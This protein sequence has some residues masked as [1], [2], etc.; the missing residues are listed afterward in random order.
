[1]PS[2]IPLHELLLAE[3]YTYVLA[4]LLQN[5]AK[6]I[7]KLTQFQKSYYEFGSIQ[8]SSGK[9]KKLKFIGLHLS[10]NYI[11]AAKTLYTEDLSN[12]TFNYLC[13][14]PPNSLCHF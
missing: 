3:L 11:P 8:T 4:T 2:L 10:K 7:Q 13:E 5:G 6:F 14:N 1:M 9:S 12:I